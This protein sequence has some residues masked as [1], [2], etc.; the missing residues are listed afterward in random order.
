MVGLISRAAASRTARIILILSSMPGVYRQHV[1]ALSQNRV[2]GLILVHA[3]Q[4]AVTAQPLTAHH[5]E[6]NCR[7]E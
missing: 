5:L 4:M 3:W 1:T 7:F 6:L 2:P